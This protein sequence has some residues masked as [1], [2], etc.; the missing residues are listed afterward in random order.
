MT[1]MTP[2]NNLDS[3]DLIESRR[4]IMKQTSELMQELDD[5]EKTFMG[6]SLRVTKNEKTIKISASQKNADR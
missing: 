1:K 4:Q 2:D 6:G 3:T 5:Y